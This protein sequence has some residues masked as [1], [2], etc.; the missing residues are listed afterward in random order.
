MAAHS[1]V[2]L[3]LLYSSIFLFVV[4]LWCLFNIIAVYHWIRLKCKKRRDNN[5]R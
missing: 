4:F 5:E 3:W 2:V 1:T